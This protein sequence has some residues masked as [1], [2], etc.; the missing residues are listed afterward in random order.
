MNLIP[1]PCFPR[2]K[3]A[4]WRRWT[5]GF[6]LFIL[7]APYSV[8]LC[9]QINLFSEECMHTETLTYY[10][11]S[12]KHFTKWA[13]M[14][15]QYPSQEREMSQHPGAF[16]CTLSA[17]PQQGWPLLWALIPQFAHLDFRGYDLFSFVPGFFHP[18]CRWDSSL[19]W[20]CITIVHCHGSRVF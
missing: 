9:L 8:L 14:C 16:W 3:H 12:S 18:V 17:S 13:Y 10:K 15:N 1:G 6:A 11:R 4:D 5:L 20:R 7:K 2:C 19:L